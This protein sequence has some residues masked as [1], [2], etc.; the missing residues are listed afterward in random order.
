MTTPSIYI[1]GSGMVTSVGAD[2]AMTAASVRAGINTYAD[3]RHYNKHG[4][5]IKMALVPEEMLPPLNDELAGLPLTARQRRLLRLATPAL[6][7]LL[8]VLP[9]QVPLPLFLAGPETLPECTSAMAP[10][11]VAWLQAQTGAKLDAKMSRVIAQGRAG[12]MQ[13]IDLAFRCF[14]S[15]PYEYALIGGID[16]Y[17]D[18]Y[19]LG[20]LDKEDRL[21]STQVSD[22]FV[23]GEAAGFLLVASERARAVQ[24]RK[25]S[26]RLMPPAVTQEAGHRYNADIPY[27][28]DGLA[29]AFAQVVNNGLP[30]KISTVYSSMNGESFGAKEYG[31]SMIRHATFFADDVVHE[32]PAD[33]FGD[34]G[35]AFLPVIIGMNAIYRQQRKH[36]GPTLAFCA[37]DQAL[38]GAICMNAV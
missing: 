34:I 28:G 38:R 8:Q 9:T 10:G 36:S 37:S 13:A 27:L 3:T 7:E 22:G 14:A 20:T 1:I 35:A 12:G 16:T 21:L 19:V 33:C 17:Y 25:A 32:H 23:P 26:L 18:P 24:D 4:E 30:G 5:P 11:F 2:S 31:V 15:T 6:Q 29:G